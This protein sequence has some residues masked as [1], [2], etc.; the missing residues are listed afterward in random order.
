M[1]VEEGCGWEKRRHIHTF[2]YEDQTEVVAC[3]VFLVDLAER[4]REVETAEEETD[5][6][7]LA[8]FG[9]YIANVT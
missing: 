5:R 3:G 1:L 9:Q 7:C 2:I 4:R 6:D 8:C